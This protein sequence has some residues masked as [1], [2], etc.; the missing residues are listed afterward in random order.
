MKG[1]HAALHSRY[2]SGMCFVPTAWVLL[3]GVAS[4]DWRLPGGPGPLRSP[5]SSSKTFLQLPRPLSILPKHLSAEDHRRASFFHLM[6]TCMH[7]RLPDDLT[8]DNPFP[9]S[10]ESA[11]LLSAT[12]V[13]LP[14]VSETWSIMGLE[15]RFAHSLLFTRSGLNT[16]LLS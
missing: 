14:A 8:T 3:G 13:I 6:H 7:V 1:R 11:G 4:P 10:K 2:L 12:E 16:P 15:L 5:R 9:P